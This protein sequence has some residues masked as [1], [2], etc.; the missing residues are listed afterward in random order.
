M[1]L[2]KNK[3]NVYILGNILLKEDSLPLRL[4]PR[5]KTLFKNISFIHLDPTE[6]I[7]EEDH[8]ILIDTI[9]DTDQIK[10]I[11]DINRIQS[12]PSYSLHDYDLA[13]N[14]K[15]MKKLNKIDKVTIIGLPFSIKE[16]SALKELKKIIPNLFSR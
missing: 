10:I 2:I 15:L 12:S 14:L 11:K 16:E 7:P 9:L 8:L 4:L 5:L 13:F 6:N 3:L 1:G